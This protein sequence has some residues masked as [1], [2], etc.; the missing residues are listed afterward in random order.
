MHNAAAAD[1]A[2]EPL[3]RAAPRS[4]RV[5]RGGRD[6]LGPGRGH[7]EARPDHGRAA[8]GAARGDEV[9]RRVGREKLDSLV[10]VSSDFTRAWQTAEEA[11][12]AVQNV[13]EFEM[14]ICAA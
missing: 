1:A 7:H 5:Q 11:L 2:Q 10:F 12:K 3:P 14:A 8:P 4:E 13:L 6:L 9:A